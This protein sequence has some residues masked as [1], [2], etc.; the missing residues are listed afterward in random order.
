M[1]W[2]LPSPTGLWPMVSTLGCRLRRLRLWSQKGVDFSFL[3]GNHNGMLLIKI[4]TASLCGIATLGHTPCI[5]PWAL[6]QCIGHALLLNLYQALHI[7]CQCI[8]SSGGIKTHY[9]Y[10][11]W[12]DNEQIWGKAWWIWGK[13]ATHACTSTYSL[14]SQA[15]V[16]SPI[17]IINRWHD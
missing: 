1:R 8:S 7:H 4:A 17:A 12:Q 16:L 13:Q 15:C 3:L 9:M 10:R 11:S 6:V 2:D 5:L 14:T